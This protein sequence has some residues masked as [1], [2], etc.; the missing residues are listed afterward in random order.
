MKRT[1]A[2]VLIVAMLLAGAGTAMAQYQGSPQQGGAAGGNALNLPPP[3]PKPQ[4]NMQYGNTARAALIAE[5]LTEASQGNARIHVN[6]ENIITVKVNLAQDASPYEIAGSMANLTYMMAGIYCLTEKPSCDIVTKVYDTSNNL[7][8]DA[9]F[10]TAKNA[11]DYF[12]VPEAARVAPT[13][14]PPMQQPGMQQPGMQQPGMQQPGM[15]Q[16]GS[17]R[18]PLQ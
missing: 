18:V 3:P 13:G 5:G 17:A 14:Q 15:Q 1:L 12:N 16:P 10:N 2:L 11:F 6:E 4:P 9:K 8:I 7:I